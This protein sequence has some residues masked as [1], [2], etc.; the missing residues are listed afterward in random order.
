VTLITVRGEDQPPGSRGKRRGGS[1]SHKRGYRL[2]RGVIKICPEVWVKLISKNDAFGEMS[3]MDEGS[4]MGGEE[5]RSSL[6]EQCDE[7]GARERTGR[8][9]F[10]KLKRSWACRRGRGRAWLRVRR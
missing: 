1:Y 10:F 5:G 8:V 7:V 2:R 6:K 3:K 4:V 9:T